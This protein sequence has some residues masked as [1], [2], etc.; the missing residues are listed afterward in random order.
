MRHPA[1]IIPMIGTTNPVHL[2]ETLEGVN[3]ELTRAE[4][5]KLYT[6]AGKPLP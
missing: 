2:R 5:F 4:W 1:G 3:V 6:A